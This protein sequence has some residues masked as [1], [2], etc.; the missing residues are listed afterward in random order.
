MSNK[1]QIRRGLQSQ[2]PTLDTGEPGFCTDTGRLYIG[3]AGANTLVGDSNLIHAA[4]TLDANADTLFGLTDQQLGLDAQAANRF[5]AGPSSGAA[6]VPTFR[7][8]TLADLPTMTDGQLIIGSTGNAPVLATL[9]G[10]ANQITV[11]NGSGSITL[12]A[13]QDLHTAAT[14]QFAGITTAYLK[15]AADSTTAVQIRT[16]GGT[17]VVNVDTTNQRVSIGT[18]VP[19]A[20]FNIVPSSTSE[21]VFRTKS[22][23]STAPLG[24][25][26]VSN[27]NFST[28]PDTSWTW[29]TGWTHD[30]TNLEADHTTGNTAALTQNIS[31]TNGQTYQVEITIRNRTAGSVMLSINGIYIYDYSTVNILTNNTTYKRS[32]VANITGTAILSITPTS[33]FNGSVDDISVKPITGVSQPNFSLLDDADSVVVELRGKSS[34]NDIALGVNALRFNTTGTYNS[35][36]GANALYAN[37]TGSYNSAIGVSALYANTTGIYNS[38]IGV[39]ALYANTTGSYN[40]AI[41]IDAGRYIASGGENQTSSNSIYLGNSTKAAADGDTNEIVIGANTIGFGS[42]TAAYGNSSIT[43]HI[44]QA[45]NVGIGMTSPDT[46]VHG[47]KS[48]N[49]TNAITNILTLE[50]SSTVTPATGFGGGINLLLKSSTT[51]AQNA[52]RIA[53]LWQTATHASRAADLVGYVSDYNAE[54]EG[55]RIR[56]TGTAAAIGFLGAAPS[57]QLAHIADPSGGSTVDTE[58]RAAI[59]SIL[60]ALETFGFLATA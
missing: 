37:T 8:L 23:Q 59:N 24:S 5:L 6:A 20:K 9:I 40:S 12:S 50:H 33:D 51:D 17:A 57:P 15:P 2:L 36:V 21:V 44:F 25:E 7:A 30:T 55:W 14:P 58:A 4:V 19:G 54:R 29:G 46:L 28:V 42:N 3:N 22:L 43:K 1:M 45:G 56:A 49:V 41:G 47:K 16:S 31:V 48:D 39:S 52:A 11:T 34:L 32:L 35:A 10:T 26:L 53:W 38:A 18:T 60:S 27:G 13:P